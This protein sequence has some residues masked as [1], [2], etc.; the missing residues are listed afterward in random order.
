[1]GMFKEYP[2]ILKRSRRTLVRG[3]RAC[4]VA[5]VDTHVIP[6]RAYFYCSSALRADCAM[7]YA[8]KMARKKPKF[9]GR[10]RERAGRWKRWKGRAWEQA[11]RAVFRSGVCLSHS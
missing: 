1:M 2:C 5:W 4:R 3:M 8:A 9:L 7:F 11:R 10:G 6:Y